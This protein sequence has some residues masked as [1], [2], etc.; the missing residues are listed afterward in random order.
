MNSPGIWT[1]VDTMNPE[2]IHFMNVHILN[3]F[4][5]HI[6]QTTTQTIIMPKQCKNDNIDIT[7]GLFLSIADIKNF[8]KN[9]LNMN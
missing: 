5:L 1:V 4:T 8:K 9:C 3:V 7:F 6:L 2:Y